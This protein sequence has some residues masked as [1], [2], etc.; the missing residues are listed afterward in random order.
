M[1]HPRPEEVRVLRAWVATGAKDDSSSVKA[2]IPDIKPRVPVNPP[3]TALAYRPDGKV[4]VAGSYREA[5]LLDVASGEVVGRLPGQNA[6]VTALAF[7]RDGRR[8]AV[9][10][11]TT[12]V[13]GEVRLYAVPSAGQLGPTPEHVLTA[14]QDV[15]LEAAFSPD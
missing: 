4:L 6:A 5:L 1:R 7:S 8:L 12:G 10:S 15:I 2:V 11:G 14:H 9:A 3:V 13:G